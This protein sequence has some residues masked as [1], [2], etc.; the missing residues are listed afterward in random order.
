MSANLENSAAASGL[1]KDRFHPNPR[2]GNAKKY[3]NYYRIAVI[4]HASKITLKNPS[5]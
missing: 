4:T 5:S 3:S 1:E 2:E